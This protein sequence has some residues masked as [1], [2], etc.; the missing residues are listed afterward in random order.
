V[1]LSLAQANPPGSTQEEVKLVPAALPVA[2]PAKA[3]YLQAG[4]CAGKRRGG[5]GGVF[6]L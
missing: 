6:R 3:V 1:R 2:L 5:G 4:V